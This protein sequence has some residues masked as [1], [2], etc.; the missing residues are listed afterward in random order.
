M[1]CIK[2]IKEEKRILIENGVFEINKIEGKNKK[3]EDEF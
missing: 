3:I 1:I 2:K